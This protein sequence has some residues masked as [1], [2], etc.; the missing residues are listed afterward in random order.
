MNTTRKKGKKSLLSTTGHLW[1]VQIVSSHR[2]NSLNDSFRYSLWGYRDSLNELF[3]TSE[4]RKGDIAF[5]SSPCLIFL[6]ARS[7]AL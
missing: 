2:P 7:H 6:P 1:F 3:L 4:Q 5:K